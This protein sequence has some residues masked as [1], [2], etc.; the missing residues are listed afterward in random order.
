MSMG[1]E[2]SEIDIGS[3]CY[4]YIVMYCELDFSYFRIQEF[5][6]YI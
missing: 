1:V 5:N 6:M 2:G 4:V 3:K